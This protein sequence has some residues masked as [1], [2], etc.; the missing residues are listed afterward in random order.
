[1]YVKRKVC[2]A[3]IKEPA[4]YNHAMNALTENATANHPAPLARPDP[5]LTPEQAIALQ[6][7]LRARVRA[8]DDPGFDLA[9]VRVVAGV[10]VSLKDAGQAAIALL[11]Y[12]DL[13]PIGGVTASAPL[14]F[15]YVPGLLSFRETPLVMQAWDALLERADLPRPDLLLVDGQGIAH[16]R[17][18]GIA[19]HVGLLTDTPAV[20]VAKSLLTGKHEIGGDE[21]GSRAFL[22]H[23]NETIGVALRAKVRTNPLIISVGHRIALETAVRVVQTCLKGYRLPEPTRR[24]HLLSGSKP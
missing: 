19:C 10:D 23:K 20:G 22:V 6:K 24:A 12:P 7:E 3:L 13:E 1:M 16:P 5:N 11:S 8:V 21:P 4:R 15:P 2:N 14:T 18:F 9:H 17:R